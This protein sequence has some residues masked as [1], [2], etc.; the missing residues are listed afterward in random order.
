[1][2]A[3]KQEYESVLTFALSLP[4]AFEDNPWGERVA[5]VGKKVFVF[6]HL[7]DN[8]ASFSVKLPQSCELALALPNVSPTGYG[9]G[10]AGWVSVVFTDGLEIDVAMLREWVTESYRAVATKKLAKQLDAPALSAIE[11]AKKR[12]KRKGA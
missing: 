7:S 11:P 10:K 3:L 4:G 2:T 1:M 6:S 5:K 9:L 8:R 12:T